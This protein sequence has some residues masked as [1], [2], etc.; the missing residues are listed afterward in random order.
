MGQRGGTFGIAVLPEGRLQGCGR[1]SEPSSTLGSSER[2]RAEEALRISEEK[3]SRVFHLSPDA[4]TINRLEDGKYLD[5]NQRFSEILGYT[6]EEVLGR[7]SVPGDLGIWVDGS[8]RDRLLEQLLARG[9]A[10]G[11][12][13]QFRRKDGS[14]L[15]GLMSAKLLDIHGERRLLAMTRDI[16][17]RKQAE[18]ALRETAQRLALATSSGKLGIWDHDLRDGSLLWDNQINRLK[19]SIGS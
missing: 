1:P 3:F 7:S 9:E 6:R 15:T 10:I 16:S 11:F 2:L 5:A 18:E 12:E 4:I 17:E 19:K 8:A 13:A 14:V